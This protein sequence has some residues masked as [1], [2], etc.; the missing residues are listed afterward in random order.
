MIEFEPLRGEHLPLL[1]DWLQPGYR[2]MRDVEEG[3]VP[4]RLMRFDR[5]YAQ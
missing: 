5:R 2:Y 1:R 3:G 4:H